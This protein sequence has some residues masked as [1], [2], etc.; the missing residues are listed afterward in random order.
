MTAANVRFLTIEG[1]PCPA[2]VKPARFSFD[3][4]GYNRGK[5]PRLPKTPC[6]MLLIAEGPHS[7]SHGIKRDPQGLN[8]GRPQWGWD[9][10]RTAPTFTPSVNCEGHCGWHGYVERGRCVNTAKQDEPEGT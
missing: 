10:D 7:A 2:P 3:C 5:D 6:G 1:E 9:G 4:V 8:G